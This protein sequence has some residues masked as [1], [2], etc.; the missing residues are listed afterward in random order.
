MPAQASTVALRASQQGKASLC[1]IAMPSVSEE[2]HELPVHLVRHWQL[3]AGVVDAEVP[4]LCLRSGSL[5]PQCLADWV[6]SC[7]AQQRGSC[8]LAAVRR[9]HAPG[10]PGAQCPV[11]QQYAG[12]RPAASCAALVRW[13]CRHCRAGLPASMCWGHTG[14]SRQAQGRAS[15]TMSV[16]MFSSLQA[17]RAGAWGM[18]LA[19]QLTFTAGFRRQSSFSI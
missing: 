3:Y 8:K 15:S 5:L 19:G 18:S 17:T 6:C 1:C 13:P 14:G 16:Q 10:I 12:Q 11:Q 9:L 4:L 7:T 2:I